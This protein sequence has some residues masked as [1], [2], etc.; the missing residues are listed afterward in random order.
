M[1]IYIIVCDDLFPGSMCQKSKDKH[2]KG[3]QYS[4]AWQF[5]Q[6]FKEVITFST[7]HI[8]RH[9]LSI[10]YLNRITTYYCYLDFNSGFFKQVEIVK[11]GL[12]ELQ[13]GALPEGHV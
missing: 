3:S 8:F 9:V 6:T 13:A 2:H 7:R 12:I 5:T 11:P 10:Y 4:R 1:A